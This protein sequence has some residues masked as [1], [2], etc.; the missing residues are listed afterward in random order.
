[1]MHWPLFSAF[2]RVVF[3]LLAFMLIVRAWM[4]ARRFYKNDLQASRQR[5]ETSQ[6]RPGWITSGIFT[7]AVI[8][9][10]LALGIITAIQTYRWRLATKAALHQT[11]LPVVVYIP[12][13]SPDQT[14]TV[15]TKF[16]IHG[17]PYSSSPIR[18]RFGAQMASYHLK[19]Y[20]DA[21]NPAINSWEKFQVPGQRQ[22]NRAI[23]EGIGLMLL[24]LLL[25]DRLEIQWIRRRLVHADSARFP[26]QDKS[27]SYV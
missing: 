7:F 4:C 25:V 5:L 17:R 13:V 8:I 2:P 6:R 1:M 21:K 20:Y 15:V 27:G 10:F 11:V 12:H 23:Y 22:L 3:G 26:P 24:G 19:L 9:A 16:R 18:I 14:Y